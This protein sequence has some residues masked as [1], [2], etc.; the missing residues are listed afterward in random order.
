MCPPTPW[1]P[2][3]GT[4]R[5]IR[6]SLELTFS[7]LNCFP[8]QQFLS[9]EWVRGEKSPNVGNAVVPFWDIACLHAQS[10]RLCC[11]AVTYTSPTSDSC[12]ESVTLEIVTGSFR[13]AA[14]LLFHFS[15]IFTYKTMWSTETEI[16]PKC[17]LCGMKWKKCSRISTSTEHCYSKEDILSN[18]ERDHKTAQWFYF[19]EFPLWLW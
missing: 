4:D 7:C 17:S 12:W 11:Y 18:I 19:S 3:N 10:H 2:Y 8:A 5:E 15:S 13:P 14:F 6:K 9:L 16:F 1:M